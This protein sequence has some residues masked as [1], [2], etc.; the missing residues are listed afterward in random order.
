MRDDH[1]A[2]RRWRGEAAGLGHRPARVDDGFPLWPDVAPPR[3][4]DLVGT[5]VPEPRREP[6][7]HHLFG[8]PVPHRRYTPPPPVRR[9]SRPPRRARVALPAA[10]GLA[11]LS[12]FFAWVTAEPF[13]L[14]LGHAAP[15]TATVETCERPGRCVGS[16]AG[17]G[18]TAARVT[19][20][21]TSPQQERAG[22]AVPARMTSARGDAAYAGGGHAGRAVT[23]V[24][25]LLLCGVALV[26]ATGA[27]RLPGHRLAAAG[28]CLA[29][30]V[31]LFAGMLAVTF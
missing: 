26:W 7:G 25:L 22:T 5:P 17:P 15:G 8:V 21:G 29:G 2:I 31:V 16:F 3:A 24:L 14:A 1:P 20:A 6:A 9:P 19:V 10:V 11:L 23:G 4:R 13:W 27:L 18:F 28:I 12:A 30:P